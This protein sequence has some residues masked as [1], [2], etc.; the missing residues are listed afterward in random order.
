MIYEIN[1]KPLSIPFLDFYW[2]YVFFEDS[3]YFLFFII[4]EFLYITGIIYIL[5]GFPNSVDLNCH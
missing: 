5:I 4:I 1:C 2:I 3:E